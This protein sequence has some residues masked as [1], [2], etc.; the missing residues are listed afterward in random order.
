VNAKKL[1]FLLALASIEDEKRDNTLTIVRGVLDLDNGKIADNIFTLSLSELIKTNAETKEAPKEAA[2]APENEEEKIRA[3]KATKAAE[4]R[5]Q[6]KKTDEDTKEAGKPVNSASAVKQVDDDFVN[7]HLPWEKEFG[8]RRG[9]CYGN[10]PDAVVK[11]T[12]IGPA[13]EPAKSDVQENLLNFEME[14]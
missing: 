6:K 14:L 1:P 10:G 13:P 7:N 9:G 5:A 8:G 4:Y 12:P 2:A 3:K 11:A